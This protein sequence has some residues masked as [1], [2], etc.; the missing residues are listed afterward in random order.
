[1]N[2]LL[3]AGVR[4]VVYAVGDP[5]PRVNGRGARLLREAGVQV[6]SGLLEA[7]AEALNEGFMMRLRRK[8][9]FIRLKS[10]ASLD[11][12]T[13][14]ANGESRWITG[15]AARADV[16]R[17]RAQS[18]AVLTSASTVLADNPRLDVR[19]ETPRQ[20]LRVILDRRRVVKKGAKILAPPGRVLIFAAASAAKSRQTAPEKF[21]DATI[22]RVK[23]KGSH[24]DLARVFARLAELQVNEVL[25]EA[26][27]RLSAA[28]LGAGLVDEW[29][30]Y[31]APKL[32]GRDARPIAAL[33]RLKRLKD[34]PGFELRESTIVGNDVRLRLRPRKKG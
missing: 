17:W 16:Q 19:I 20:P 18:A 27:P 6:E 9:P 13:A 24:L 30:V 32:L 8:R 7:E 11:G 14:L 12:K 28:L 29:L 25:V 15:E 21:G 1:V 5:D 2:G 33:P 4:R 23:R 34:A 22:E 3:E 31:L 26:G 10:G